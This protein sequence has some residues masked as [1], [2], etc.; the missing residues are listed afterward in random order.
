MGETVIYGGEPRLFPGFF[1]IVRRPTYHWRL[2]ILRPYS[3]DPRSGMPMIDQPL[4]G[5]IVD[6]D[7]GFLRTI[8]EED[9]G[10]EGG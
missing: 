6:E 2:G 3:N 10:E 9:E 4:L 5:S 1:N 7:D 8:V